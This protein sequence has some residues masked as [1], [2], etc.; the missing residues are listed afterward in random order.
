SADKAIWFNRWRTL[1]G[2]AEK[3][4]GLCRF[5][6][7]WLAMA[8]SERYLP[9]LITKIESLLDEAGLNEE[10]ITIRMTGCP[11]G[12][13]RPALAEIAFIGKAPGKYNMYLGGGFAGDRLNKLYKENIDEAVIL[14]S[15]RPI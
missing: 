8:E 6:Y 1:Y 13:A 9:S 10:E 15:L 12:C 11:N 2:I 7:L 5:S 3:F 14:E 4:Y